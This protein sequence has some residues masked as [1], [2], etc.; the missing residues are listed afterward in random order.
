MDAI[1]SAV[2][3]ALISVPLIVAMLMI[4]VSSP[5]PVFFVQ[6]RLG[7][8]RRPFRILKLRSMTVDPGRTL[9]QTMNSNPEVFLIGKFLRRFKIDELPQ[10]FN[11]LKGDMS[12]VGPRPCLEETLAGMPE[13]AQRRFE[14]RP[15]LTGLA[16]VNGNVALSWEERWRHDVDYVQ[17]LNFALDMKI[18]AKTLL[19][20]VWGESRYRNSQ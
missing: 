4:L 2:L 19:V 7:A 20:L 1:V 6:S 9:T 11:V 16:Q 5:G 10:L 8:S 17:K 15:G 12:L 13:W 14:V 18:M 3:L